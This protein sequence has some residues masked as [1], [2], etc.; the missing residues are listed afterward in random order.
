MD[1]RYIKLENIQKRYDEI[2]EMLSSE[3]IVKDMKQVTKLSK[4]QASLREAYLAYQEL[5]S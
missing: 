2:S 5:K 1:A 4:E 3:D